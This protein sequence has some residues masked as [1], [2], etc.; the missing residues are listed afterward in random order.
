LDCADPAGI[1]PE[2]GAWSSSSSAKGH[3]FARSASSLVTLLA[4]NIIEIVRHET[5]RLLNALGALLFQNP[6]LVIKIEQR[7]SWSR[8]ATVSD[9][10]NRPGLPGFSCRG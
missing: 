9:L 3:R 6:I 4:L 1:S 8:K 7:E 10:D 5:C 2:T